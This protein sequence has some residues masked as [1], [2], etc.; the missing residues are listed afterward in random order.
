M[1]ILSILTQ[2]RARIANPAY[3]A[4]GGAASAYESNSQYC[5]LTA[6]WRG[7]D[8]YLDDNIYPAMN[9]LAETNTIPPRF[10]NEPARY[11]IPA[12]NDSHTHEEVL[13]AFD[14]AIAVARTQA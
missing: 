3:W 14:R 2:A 8:I 4:Q 1:S 10:P 9:L 13:A 12:W 11:G 5:A 7:R 6:I